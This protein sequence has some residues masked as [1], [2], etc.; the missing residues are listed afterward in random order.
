MFIGRF[1][2]QQRVVWVEVRLT[3]PQGGRDFRFILDTGT[4][5]TILNTAAADDLGYSHDF[6][7]RIGADGLVGMDLLAG[8]VLTL[9][10]I[11]G[12]IAVSP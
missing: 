7:E 8:R 3:G 10:G 6:D 12:L 5:V 9:D 11:Q 1:D 4:P 2:P